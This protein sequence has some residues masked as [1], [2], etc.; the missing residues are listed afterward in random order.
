MLTA[1]DLLTLPYT[2][3]LTEGGITYACRSLAYTY[4]RMGGSPYER[5]RRIVAGVIVELA[6]RRHLSGENTPFDVLGATPFTDPDHYDLSLGGHRCDVKSFLITHREQISQIRH[7][8]GLVL[9]AP[10][11]VPADQLAAEG[12]ANRDLY[13]FAFLLALT[14]PAEADVARALAAG[15]PVCLIHP[16]PDAW[17]RPPAWIPLEG[18]ALKSECAA[19]LT[20]EIGGQESGREFV[21]L[22]LELPPRTRVAVE[23]TFFSLAYVHAGRRPEVR[24]GLHSPVRGAPYLIPPH[25]WGN[26]WVYGLSILLAGYMTYEEFRRKARLLPAGSS[27][28]QYARTRT[29]NQCVPVSELHPLRE[30]FERVRTRAG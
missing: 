11:L 24:V 16:L 6:L 19:P 4:D 25:A 10:A 30:L 13:L 7:D 21:T 26:I 23:R 1:N 28:F 27:T 18:L 17:V 14:A 9:E 22:K 8:P 15:Q 29:K 20:V 5:L 3:D 12:H 2:P